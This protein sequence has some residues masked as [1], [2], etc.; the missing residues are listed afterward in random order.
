MESTSSDPLSIEG[1]EWIFSLGGPS[2]LGAL[3]WDIV[4]RWDVQLREDGQVVVVDY[5]KEVMLYQLA[6]QRT[7]KRTFLVWNIRLTTLGRSSKMP[8]VN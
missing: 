7:T 1:V 2:D 3:A 6:P 5:W 8:I 4:Y